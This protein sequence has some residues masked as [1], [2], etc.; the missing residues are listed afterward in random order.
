MKRRMAGN[1]RVGINWGQGARTHRS[2]NADGFT[3]LGERQQVVVLHHCRQV[4]SQGEQWAVERSGYRVDA[5]KRW[6]GT[7]RSNTLSLRGHT[8]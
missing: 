5:S 1:E 8:C 7:G 4:C 6:A 2:L 3:S